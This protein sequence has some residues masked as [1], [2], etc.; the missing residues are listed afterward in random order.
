[1]EKF[2]KSKVTVGDINEKILTRNPSPPF[3]TSSMQQAS[4]DKLMKDIGLKGYRQQ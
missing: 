3:S 2:K 1:M 4:A